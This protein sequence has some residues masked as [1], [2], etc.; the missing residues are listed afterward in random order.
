[1]GAKLLCTVAIAAAGLMILT[2]P[3]PPP[4]FPV[5][6]AYLRALADVHDFCAEDFDAF[7]G[8]GVAV[9]EEE[10]VP[11]RRLATM[12]LQL[13]VIDAE[14]GSHGPGKNRAPLRLGR[15]EDYCLRANYKALSQ[16][17]AASIALVDDAAVKPKH[18]GVCPF[19]LGL[20]IFTLIVFLCA[21]RKVR[22]KKRAARAIFEAIRS[23]E[24]LKATVEAKSGVSIPEPCNCQCGRRA[25][26]AIVIAV[27]LS[28]LVGPATVVVSA[29]VAAAVTGC[30]KS[31]K[32][33]SAEV[34]PP[35]YE[36]VEKGEAKAEK[37]N[38]DSLLSEATKTDSLK[39]PLL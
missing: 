16:E 28:L 11:A 15:R 3:R 34:A 20:V 12:F 36:E 39:K 18:H 17:C 25:C 21:A 22:A 23:D 1:M 38:T 24:T 32:R 6:G 30:V 19:M 8:A 13:D 31:C 29:L 26:K 37:A 33:T 27:C 7:C 35:A 5:D 10:P 4:P 14:E 2:A 9:Q